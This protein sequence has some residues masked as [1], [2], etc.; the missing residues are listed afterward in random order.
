V[1]DLSTTVVRTSTGAN[2][3]LTTSTETVVQS[4]VPVVEVDDSSGLTTNAKIALGIGIGFGV[5]S[6]FVA[7]LGLVNARRNRNIALQ[8]GQMAGQLPNPQKSICICQ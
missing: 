5:P 3:A 4:N 2:G 1:V 7:I 8:Q 6:L